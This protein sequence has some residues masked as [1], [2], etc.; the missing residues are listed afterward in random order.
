MVLAIIIIL[1]TILRAANLEKAAAFN[2]DQEV[3]AFWLKNLLVDHKFSLIGQEISVGGVYIAPFFYYL[4]A[5]F[6]AL[7]NLTLKEVTIKK[8]FC[9]ENCRRTFHVT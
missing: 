5:P 1:G 8:L 6:Y 7:F 4:M 9:V 3:A 2:Y